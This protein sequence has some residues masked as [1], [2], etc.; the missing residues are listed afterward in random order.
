MPSRTDAGDLK[1]DSGN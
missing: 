1:F